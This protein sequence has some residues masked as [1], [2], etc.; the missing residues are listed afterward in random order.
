[1]QERGC[2]P[3][4]GPASRCW[5]LGKLRLEDNGDHARETRDTLKTRQ[6][7]W[8]LWKAPGQSSLRRD[9]GPGLAGDSAEADSMVGA[10]LPQ[11]EHNARWA[12][13]APR[14]WATPAQLTSAP[15]P[16]S[17]REPSL[18]SPRPPAKRQ[19]SADRAT[20]EP[21]G[22]S[23]PAGPGSRA[24]PGRPRVRAPH[25]PAPQARSW[26]NRGPNSPRRP[27]SPCE[28]RTPALTSRQKSAGSDWMRPEKI[29]PIPWRRG[30]CPRPRALPGRGHRAALRYHVFPTPNQNSEW[31]VR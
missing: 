2:E 31:E 6:A 10:G 25:S 11:R 17:V 29:R 5:G 19:G 4:I 28:R 26:E 30:T 21:A 22:L 14:R 12:G 23:S 8:R 24:E 18:L 7:G 20:E 15:G 13:S 16:V 1:M 9:M 27:L 3:G